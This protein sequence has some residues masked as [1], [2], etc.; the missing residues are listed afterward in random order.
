MGMFVLV[1]A[2][3]QGHRRSWV[4]L[5]KGVISKRPTPPSKPRSSWWS[6]AYVWVHR[7]SWGTW[8]ISEWMQDG[9]LWAAFLLQVTGAPVL[10]LSCHPSP[11][12]PIFPSYSRHAP[13]PPSPPARRSP[14]PFFIHQPHFIFFPTCLNQHL[15]EERAFRYVLCRLPSPPTRTELGRGGIILCLLFCATVFSE[16]ST[17]AGA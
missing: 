13:E 5:G 8:H 11:G 2:H 16:S 9:G 4:S 15:T 10:C 14:L 1:L 6:L 3:C 7:A 17:G 12:G